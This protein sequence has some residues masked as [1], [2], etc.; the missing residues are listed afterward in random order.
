GVDDTCPDV[1][2]ALAAAVDGH[3]RD[4]GLSLAGVLERGPGARRARLVDR[5]DDV[6]VPVLLQAVLH[7]RLR[8]GHLA[9]AVPNA[10]DLLVVVL[11][12]EALEEAVVPERS[13][14]RADMLVDHGNR[15]LL[16]PRG[17]ARVAPDQDARVEVVR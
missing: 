12:P 15:D 11:D 7:R 4:A 6:D 8:R 16:A 1:A 5:V 14:R 13:D 9:V 17:G 3:H 10:G 2:H